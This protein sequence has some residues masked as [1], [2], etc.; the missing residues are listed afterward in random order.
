MAKLLAQAQRSG[1]A[2]CYCESWNLES[3]VAV[4]E[5]AEELESPIITGFNGGFLRHPGRPKQENLAYYA[6]MGSALRDSKAQGSL[7]LNE[8]DDFSQIERGIELGFNAVMVENEHMDGG[9]YKALVKSIV[10]LAHP[11]GVF[12]EAAVGHLA[13]GAGHLK[14]EKTDL[15][16]ARALVEETGIDALGVAVG[17]VHILTSGK[18]SINLELL[19]RVHDAVKVPLV[20]HGGTGIPLESAQDYIKRGV[21][22]INFGTNLKQVYLR[23]IREGLAQYHEP[24]NPHPFIGMGGRE[25][26]LMA[27]LEAVK[28]KV[29]ELIDSC[30]SAGMA[31]D[32]AQ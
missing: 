2:V 23:A 6:G 25:D 16:M 10:S 32:G 15:S 28:K 3:F 4:V 13:D 17:N 18:A 24:M 31:H 20:L 5:A 26:L 29:K 14:G 19:E 27:G 21:A 8:T 12:V 1:Y 30:G 7:L 11:R 9:P 22:K